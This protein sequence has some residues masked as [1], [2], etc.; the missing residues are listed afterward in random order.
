MKPPEN[1]QELPLLETIRALQAGQASADELLQACDQAREDLMELRR[2]FEAQVQAEHEN[3]RPALAPEIEAVLRSFDDY[4]SLLQSCASYAQD[5]DSERLE[6]ALVGVPL[7]ATRLSLDFQR[8]RE[9]ALAQRGPTTHPGVNLVYTVATLLRRGEATP[10]EWQTTLDL[11]FE[12]AQDWLDQDLSAFHAGAELADLMQRYVGLLDELPDEA[13]WDAWLEELVAVGRDYAFVDGDA[14][15]RRYG[16]GPT[17]VPWLNLLLNTAWLVGQQAASPNLL[18]D[19]LVEAHTELERIVEAFEGWASAQ[20]GGAGALELLQSFQ[21]WVLELDAWLESCDPVELE[22]LSRQGMELASRYPEVAEQLEQAQPGGGS[23]CTV[24]GGPVR[25]GRCANCGS[26]SFV[27]SE[28]SSSAGASRVEQVVGLA[29]RVLREAADPALL[30]P[31][32]QALER[33]LQVA[34]GK[35]PGSGA[36]EALK[37]LRERYTAALDLFEEGL[38]ALREFADEPAVTTLQEAE[39]NL[40]AAEAELADIQTQL[41]QLK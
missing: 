5:F 39:E 33:D 12:R 26:R 6:S 40:R 10:E 35:D 27:A 4:A 23:R 18:R 41:S 13:G 29:E 25:E 7:A 11:E 14:V 34:R 17:P 31:H 21:E 2:Q 37:P 22:P 1:L 16:S 3:V 19:F 9:V 32:L 20:P 24:C 38:A 30:D 15:R 28:A 8:F 36:D